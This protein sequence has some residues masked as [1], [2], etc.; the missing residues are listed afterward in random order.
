M[1]KPRG[2]RG[3]WFAMWQGESL[4]CVHICWTKGIWP[5]H[6]DPG[7]DDNPK[8]GPFIAALRHGRAILT[9]DRLD[10]AGVP[11]GRAGYIALYRIENVELR[12]NALHFDFKERLA[13]FR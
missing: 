10:G 4:P 12:D 7:V 9:D 11:N 5:H 3:N 2:E 6:C 8:W 1:A 13:D